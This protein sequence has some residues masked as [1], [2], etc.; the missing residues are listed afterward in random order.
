M[1]TTQATTET[2]DLRC[3]RCGTTVYLMRDGNYSTGYPSHLANTC[4]G[5]HFHRVAAD[6]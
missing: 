2:T 6:G 3:T 5:L 1:T 4:D